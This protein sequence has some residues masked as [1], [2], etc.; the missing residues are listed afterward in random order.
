MKDYFYGLLRKYLS[1]F[2]LQDNT[3][4]E[5]DPQSD[6]LIAAFPRGYAAFRS[7]APPEFAVPRGGL[8]PFRDIPTVAPDVL[9]LGGSVH[10]E[11]DIQ[12]L[13]RELHGLSSASTRLLITYYS[14]LWRPLMRLATWLGLR[15]KTPELNWLAN[16]DID[17][18]L[19]LEGFELVRRDHRVLVPVWI[20][21]VSDF[22]NRYLAP[23]PIIRL[24]CILNV[25]VARPLGKPVLDARSS[26]SVVVP[27]RNEAGNIEA[28][29]NRLPAL[30]PDDEIIFVEGHSTDNTWEVI[31]DI[32]RR[33]GE[34]KRITSA[35]QDGKGKGDA[36]R[37]GFGLARNEI[38][39][40]L[41]ADMT[42]PPEDLVN[43]YRAITTDKAE[44]VN[45]S[46]LIYPMEQRAMRF[47]NLIGNKF[48]A[49][50]F[51]FVLGQRFK[52]T[53]CGTKVISK[54][55]YVRLAHHRSYFGDFDP[56]GDF[57]LI[58]GAARM[59][60]KT[61]E[62]PVSYRERTYGDTNISRWRH[63]LILL[64]MLTF[65]ARRIKFI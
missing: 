51:S 59:C 12:S 37:K 55:N 26:V 24:F 17:N 52:D 18:L 38:L 31:Q 58:F 9:L 48:F 1:L 33:Y 56:F 60:L 15:T 14:S 8:L 45:G 2:V 25:V 28:I 30:G 50:A 62:V 21:L 43:F 36:V 40:I 11:R 32:Q 41:D 19:A 10:Y 13:L 63:G 54:S 57:D 16:E 20:P 53:L 4:V 64:A 46:R 29:V 22:I 65:A 42:V 7:S 23:L 35:Q 39:I 49:V 47:M 6:L 3:I 34:H 44:F 27:A 5:I 61:T